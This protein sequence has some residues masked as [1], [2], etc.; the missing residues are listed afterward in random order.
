MKWTKHCT[1]ILTSV[2]RTSSKQ[3]SRWLLA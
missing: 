3:K 1:R 2:W